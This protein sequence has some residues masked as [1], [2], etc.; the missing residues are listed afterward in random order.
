MVPSV[1]DFPKSRVTSTPGGLAHPSLTDHPFRVTRDR[2]RRGECHC[3]SIGSFGAYDGHGMTYLS[4]N[5][6]KTPTS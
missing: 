2:P 4:L 1:V 5:G 6:Y 3:H